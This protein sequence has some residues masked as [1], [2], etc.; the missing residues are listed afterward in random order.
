MGGV[1][2]MLHVNRTL[3]V[4]RISEDTSMTFRGRSRDQKAQEDPTNP[5]VKVVRRHFSEWGEL[6]NG[7]WLA[8]IC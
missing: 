6:A 7:E 1:G 4:G 5:M 3:Y 8:C 2:S